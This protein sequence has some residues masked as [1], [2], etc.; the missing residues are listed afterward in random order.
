MKNV[1][2]VIPNPYDYPILLITDIESATDHVH[3]KVLNP[4][5]IIE[6]EFNIPSGMVPKVFSYVRG[7]TER[8]LVSCHVPN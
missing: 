1:K 5:A 3:N 7:G 8:M 2:L 6:C 4:G